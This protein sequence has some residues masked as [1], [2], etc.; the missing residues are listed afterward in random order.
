MRDKRTVDE[1]S[2]E[3]LERILAIRKR[4]ERQGKLKRM[5]RAGRVVPSETAKGTT[6][7]DFSAIVQQ[8]QTAPA[9]PTIAA[10][11]IAATNGNNG[12]NPQFED[13]AHAAATPY[14]PQTGNADRFWKAFVNQSLLLVEVMAIVGLV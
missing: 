3:E 6:A 5:E 12:P 14:K 2:I 4:E 13:D 10:P 7:P 11:P 9:M 8:T 1:L